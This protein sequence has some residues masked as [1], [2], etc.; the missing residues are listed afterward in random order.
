M[1]VVGR[2]SPSHGVIS[3]MSTSFNLLWTRTPPMKFVPSASEAEERDG[4]SAALARSPPHRRLGS[5]RHSPQSVSRW[6]TPAPRLP[7]ALPSIGSGLSP[8]RP[9]AAEGDVLG[10]PYLLVPDLAAAGEEGVVQS[11]D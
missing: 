7:K 4:E 2:G 1:T 11:L 9:Q 8:R 6:P 3:L 5:P 10:P